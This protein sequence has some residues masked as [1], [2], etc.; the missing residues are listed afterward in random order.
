MA[1]TPTRSVFYEKKKQIQLLSFWDVVKGVWL[2]FSGNPLPRPKFPTSPPKHT[3]TTPTA[4]QHALRRGL[5]C[6]AVFRRVRRFIFCS[7]FECGSFD[8]QDVPYDKGCS[9]F[10]CAASCLLLVLKK[11]QTNTI[12]PFFRV[13]YEGFDKSL[14]LCGQ[15]FGVVW[16][17]PWGCVDK[18]LGSLWT[19]PWTLRHRGGVAVGRLRFA[20]Q[21]RLRTSG[22]RALLSHALQVL[23]HK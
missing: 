15:L 5:R 14:G 2:V 3:Q 7:F 19:S 12:C 17:S 13:C 21:G 11:Q 18:S 6:E 1:A 16:T 10:H 23:P 9:R 22:R 4:T 20:S 8:G